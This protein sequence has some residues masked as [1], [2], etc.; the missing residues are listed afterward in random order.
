[1]IFDD[2]E[3]EE[4]SSISWFRL[5]RPAPAAG[6]ESGHLD[7]WTLNV[8]FCVPRIM[9]NRTLPNG[10]RGLTRPVN[11]Y[12]TNMQRDKSCDFLEMGSI[13]ICRL[14]VTACAMIGILLLQGCAQDT[15][16]ESGPIT[17]GH[18]NITF[19]GYTRAGVI[20]SGR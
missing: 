17:D 4:E 18:S 19:S 10:R 9:K 1:M 3:H 16:P 11:I 14:I 7:L 13:K 2:N 15:P 8:R 5:N 20:F 12:L 6:I